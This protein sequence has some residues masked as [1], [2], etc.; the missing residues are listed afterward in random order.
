MSAVC[1]SCGQIIEWR[2]QPDGHRVPLDRGQTPLGKVW[3]DGDGHARFLS[4][5]QQARA[6]AK[7]VPLRM[8]HHATCPQ[9]GRHAVPRAQMALE[10]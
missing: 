9:R 5:E 10:L 2:Q 6:V 8:P 4:N 7:G 3:I 1:Q